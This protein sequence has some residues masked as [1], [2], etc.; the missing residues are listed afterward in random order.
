MKK[1]LRFVLVSLFGF[2]ISVAQ[3][4][5][6]EDKANY[7]ADL[8]AYF[9]PTRNVNFMAQIQ[10]FDEQ[11]WSNPQND[12]INKQK[13]TEISKKMLGK[14][15]VQNPHFLYLM[16][17]LMS[18][19]QSQEMSQEV[20]QHFFQT[21][22]L[23]IDYQ[24]N[25]VLLDFLL[26]SSQFFKTRSVFRG[27]N[28][29]CTVVD[30][31]FDFSYE[32]VA[33]V[34]QN[35]DSTQPAP[36]PEPVL[37]SAAQANIFQSN[38]SLPAV[39]GPVLKFFDVN[40]K[41]GSRF[42]TA[43]IQK[44]SGSFMFNSKV[45]VG[46]GGKIDW[47]VLDKELA[48]LF[49][50][51]KG[52]SFNTTNNF[53][54]IEDAT[55]TNEEKLSSKIDGI[56]EFRSE[57]HTRTYL[58][59]YPKF[60]SY[61]N[62]V[63]LPK[64]GK[65]ISYT[66]GYAIS[67][68][69]FSSSCVDGKPASLVYNDG[70]YNFDVIAG[71]FNFKDSTISADQAFV[72]IFID[73]DTLSH[74]SLSFYLETEQ[75]RLKLQRTKGPY[76]NAWFTDTYHKLEFSVDNITWDLNADSMDLDINAAKTQIPAMFKSGNYF[77]QKEFFKIQSLNQFHPL[78]ILSAYLKKSESSTIV[79]DEL[80]NKMKIDPIAFKGAMVDLDRKGFIIYE[81]ISGNIIMK[82]KGL[83]Y[84]LS[85][86]AKTDYD[87]LYL[88]SLSPKEPNAT[89]EFK[90]KILTIRG[91]EKFQISDSA[92]VYANPDNKTVKIGYNREMDFD[93]RI[94][95]GT[96]DMKGK[97]FKFRYDDY[98]LTMKQ[99]D[100][101]KFIVREKDPKT[102]KI[103]EKKLENQ[104]EQSSGTIYINDPDNKSGKKKMPQYP[105]FDA[106]T[107]ANVYFNKK[108]ILNGAYNRRVYFKIP[109]FKTDSV[110]SNQ[111]A[112]V[113]F[114]GKFI[115][116][117]IFP[118]FDETLKIMPDN[119]L[120][121]KHK[122]PQ[123]GY[124]L[125]GGKGKFFGTLSLD[126]N[127]IRG[128]GKIEYLSSVWQ[129]ND[130]VFYQDSVL[131]TGQQA[132]IKEA[133]ISDVYFPDVE[134]Y[135][136]EMKWDTK[137][138]SMHIINIKDPFLLYKKQ[139]SLEGSLNITPKGLFGAGM[140][141]IKKTNVIGQFLFKD[142]NVSA[143]HAVFNTRAAG[144][145]KPTMSA[146]NMRVNFNLKDS[147]AD[148]SPE[149]PGLA[150]L[151]FPLN[152][153]KT[154]IE[155]AHWDINKKVV[156]MRS[157][158]DDLSKS[159]FYTTNPEK[160]SL[161]FNAAGGYYDMTKKLLKIDGI[162]FIK[163]ADSKIIPDSNKVTVLA[164]AALKPFSNAQLIIDTLNGY[165]YLDKGKI[166]IFSR[167]KFNGTARYK[168]ANVGGDTMILS[169]NNFFLEKKKTG[170][171]DTLAYTV[172][173][174][175][176]T[177]S[178]KFYIS[179]KI[180]Y[181][182]KVKLD[183]TS[184]IL[185]F[186]GKVKIDI[187]TK[188]LKTDWFPYIS[189]GKSGEVVIEL[190][191]PKEK[192][193][194]KKKEIAV[195]D[196]LQTE[197]QN[198]EVL[199][200]EMGKLFTGLFYETG[201]HEV[202]SGVVSTKR[203]E[204]D[205]EIFTSTG[206]LIYDKPTASF[207]IG[208]AKRLKNEVLQGNLFNYNDSSSVSHSLGKFNLMQ[209]DQHFGLTSVGDIKG[210][211]SKNYFLGNILFIIKMNMPP[212][213]LEIMSKAI[214][215][216]VEH[217]DHP[218]KDSTTQED[219]E[220]YAMQIAQT[221]GEK[222]STIYA[223]DQMDMMDYKP[224]FRYAPKLMEGLCLSHVHLNWSHAHKAWHNKL[225]LKISNILGV[226][227]NRRVKGYLE[228]KKSDNG[229]NFTLFLHPRSDTWF[230]INY[231][232]G[233]LSLLSS[234]AGFTK[235]VSEKSKGETGSP[236]IYTFVQSDFS[237][238]QDFLKAFYKNYLNKEYNEEEEEKEIEDKTEETAEPVEEFIDA[239]AEAEKSKKGNKK[240]K[241]PKTDETEIS[242]ENVSEEAPKPIEKPKKEKKNK[243]KPVIEEAPAEEKTLV[244]E[245][246]LETPKPEEKPKKEKKKKE[247][248]VVE[249]TPAVEKTADTEPAT[250]TPVKE[251]KKKKDKKK[252]KDDITQEETPA[253][254]KTEEPAE[255]EPNLEEDTPKKKKKK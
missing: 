233:R 238:K 99:I 97:D 231:Q 86:D 224:L 164:G 191:K 234:E 40:L 253:E 66:G 108:E 165:H 212:K 135:D 229:D 121:F 114:D 195:V 183:A 16:N 239:E 6:F 194:A 61:S 58:A 241:K 187:K 1:L 131:A 175:V 129:C 4:T 237:E 53:L 145:P 93:G 128:N 59:N 60:I 222:L 85:M 161:A 30:G 9:A 171:K 240:S 27:P 155:N 242:D 46:N 219:K 214:K 70:K 225:H 54:H 185:A 228:I 57:R 100:S 95:A 189:D 35:S 63:S 249:E 158:T 173:Q 94:V 216:A 2:Q 255:E 132:K 162:P 117:G 176:I 178:Q 105:K 179:P 17:T 244:P 130:F 12:E 245:P 77:T 192:P 157:E 48:K 174:G 69:K 118:E 25:K 236:L 205:D 210:N 62:N 221:D 73:G 64:I 92:N 13:V 102:G 75:K 32:G 120:G 232:P 106:E 136:F 208:D 182:G 190:S 177:E 140:L 199:D 80:I 78:R 149:T 218:F 31:K 159:Y 172:S 67:G 143:R 71:A 116:A 83:N 247:K 111:K 151:E 122:V 186:D 8:K 184:K 5:I 3:T 251:E 14:G 223:K 252:K 254:E 206:Q 250:E 89:I 52:Y 24:E 127:G 19:T 227:I 84:V 213:A 74:P 36:A 248:P 153:F 168:F 160:D 39:E 50:E 20:L 10:K 7:I 198:E 211:V 169:F 220:M 96:Y 207:R 82:K 113:K 44:T 109:P 181:K 203:S 154:S 18:S 112:T 103:V 166:E 55:F 11:Y 148:I 204:S 235:A 163:V 142:D 51:F 42:D 217:P 65:S 197:D 209:T 246:T 141:E 226:D 147:Y 124:D 91:V 56:F 230:Y 119:S 110:K 188:G 201:V 41:L 43:I 37:D 137:A 26:L 90:N 193:Q 23:T 200:E 45:F 81:P 49:V 126:N 243:E 139:L 156:T 98:S 146:N 107:G 101:I 138:D 34:L 170:R 125:Y 79:A 144:S 150:G 196:T 180:L 152:E 29:S 115:S 134:I 123:D 202:Y 22:S 87:A 76:K 28:N 104:L 133:T 15:A 68:V 38:V 167:K 72:Q 88:P 21:L 33:S 47:T 215:D